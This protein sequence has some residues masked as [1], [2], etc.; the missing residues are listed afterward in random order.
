MVGNNLNQ[1]YSTNPERE[2][3][4]L[5][6]T[7]NRLAARRF[8]R[9]FSSADTIRLDFPPNE[10]SS[11][12]GDPQSYVTR[13]LDKQAE[14]FFD[15]I[16]A[17]DS[18]TIRTEYS[19]YTFLVIDPAERA[20]ILTGGKL[21]RRMVRATLVGTLDEEDSDSIKDESRLRTGAP[22]LFHLKSAQGVWRI[23]TSTITDL[24]HERGPQPSITD[25]TL[26]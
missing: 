20:G 5:M 3:E 26:V 6:E 21:K 13:P 25:R 12:I 9:R 4:R 22:A 16:R 23:I 15:D 18:L 1:R 2:S 14:V 19:T 17:S 8:S 24:I 11:L 7:G 10:K